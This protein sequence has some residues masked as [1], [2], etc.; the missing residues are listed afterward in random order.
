V[1]LCVQIANDRH[2]ISACHLRVEKKH[3]RLLRANQRNDL[4]LTARYPDDFEVRYFGNQIH[5][6]LEKM[7]VVTDNANAA[8]SNISS[9][10]IAIWTWNNLVIPEVTVAV[11][12]AEISLCQGDELRVVQMDVIQMD[13][14]G[15]AGRRRGAARGSRR[16]SSP[17]GEGRRGGGRLGAMQAAGVVDHPSSRR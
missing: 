12:A 11:R 17:C 2:R 14:A 5:Q 6:G 9:R 13:E 16:G 4:L 10:Y 8:L 15:A 1:V 7:R 3:V